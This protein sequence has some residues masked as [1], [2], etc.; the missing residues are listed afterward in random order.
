[1]FLQIVSVL[2]VC[3]GEIVAQEETRTMPTDSSDS[4]TGILYGK[5]HAFTLTAPSGWVLDNTSGV[6]QGLYAV[7]YARG[8]SWQH[9]PAVMYGKG[10]SKDIE[11][12]ET[13]E[14][15]IH[16]D[17]VQFVENQPGVKISSSSP[18]QTRLGRT[19]IV[20]TFS[21]SQEEIV[22]YIDEPTIVTTIVLTARTKDDYNAAFPFFKEL[23]ASY[24]FIS[25]NHLEKLTD[26]ADAMKAANDNLKTTEGKLYDDAV[27]RRAGKWL[28]QE[29]SH[30]IAGLDSADLRPFTV[31]IR[32]GI[33]GKAEEVLCEPM[34]KVASCL[35]SG[36]SAAFYP[37]PPGGS[38]WV[39]IDLTI[40]G[41]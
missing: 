3:S 7:F 30:C 32:V 39:K 27:G 8:G 31:V 12:K 25:N 9:S 33:S 37:K 20:R 36:F 23:V 24:V 17:S 21:Y 28:V 2:L 1:M 10:T 41:D 13:I 18:I 34:T 38:W 22:A 19:A 14:Q 15:F 16:N 11:A 29:I 26:F 35:E 40:K 4:N 6:S 5:D